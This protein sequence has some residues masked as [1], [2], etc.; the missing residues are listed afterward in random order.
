L[1]VTEL[2]DFFAGTAEQK[3]STTTPDLLSVTIAP[4]NCLTTTTAVKADGKTPER[5]A[6]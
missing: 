1:Q 3:S 2:L 5:H 6:S 4:W